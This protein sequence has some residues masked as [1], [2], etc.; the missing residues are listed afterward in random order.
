MSSGVNQKTPL[1]V[2]FFEKSEIDFVKTHF[3][4]NFLVIFYELNQRNK[5]Q[6]V[7]K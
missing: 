7:Q 3:K 5:E 4:K 1:L 2:K 6:K